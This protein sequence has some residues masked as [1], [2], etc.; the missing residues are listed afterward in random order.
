MLFLLNAW[1]E[2]I[3]LEKGMVSFISVYSLL[4]MQQY[5]CEIGLSLVAGLFHVSALFSS[6]YCKVCFV[7]GLLWLCFLNVWFLVTETWGS[8]NHHLVLW[9]PSVVLLNTIFCRDVCGFLPLHFVWKESPVSVPP[10]ACESLALPFKFFILPISLNSIP[11]TRKHLLL[12]WST[13]MR[14]W[15][16]LSCFVGPC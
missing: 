1:G 14:F 11:S 5:W 16:G 8:Q 2:A 7:L 12:C 3:P 13:F 6:L 4:C 10:G 9:K 15:L